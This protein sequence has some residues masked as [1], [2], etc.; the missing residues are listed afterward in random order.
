MR[1]ELAIY[2][3]VTGHDACCDLNSVAKSYC[4][5]QLEHRFHKAD[6]DGLSEGLSEERSQCRQ[7]CCVDQGGE[8]R[9][10]LMATNPAQ[11]YRSLLSKDFARYINASS[12]DPCQVPVGTS[13]MPALQ[14]IPLLRCSGDGGSLCVVANI[15]C[16]P[17][18]P[19]LR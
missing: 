18:L 12:L 9:E 4:Q 19:R 2:C 10:D 15:A 7:S 5:G 1:N 8:C 16:Y 13:S 14:H 11:G 17:L 6:M 3:R